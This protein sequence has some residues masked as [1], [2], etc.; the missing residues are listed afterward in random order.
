MN[1]KT[2]P[3]IF[4]AV[5]LCGLLT[6]HA[7]L[8]AQAADVPS[9]AGGENMPWNRGVPGER[10]AAARQLFLEGNRLFKIP[11]FA[12]AVEKYD[13]ALGQWR[14]PAFYFNLALAQLNLG[15]DLEARDSL[16]R[17]LKYGPEPLGADRFTEAQNQHREL[18][19]HLGRIRVS[20]PTEGAEITLDGLLLFTGPG[21]QDVWVKPQAHD[22]AAKRADYATRSSHVAVA[23]GA[24]KALDLPLRKLIEDRPWALWKPW[25][26]VGSGVAIAA[27]GGMLHALSARNFDAYDAGFVKLPCATSGCTQQELDQ[28]TLGARLHRARLEQDLAV[29]GYIAGAVVIAAGVALVYMNRP[30]LTEQSGAE[31]HSTG[32]SMTP[33]ISPGTL[34]VLV[35]VSR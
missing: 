27:A 26:V 12:Q 34:G 32:V 21:S 6:G 33:V 23:P 4:I 9:A 3:W 16:E 35:T 13:E 22:V 28:T 2:K 24:L 31:L 17:A 29:G 20:C 30:H 15:Q 14:H 8:H 1:M 7:S 18:Q 5:M 10:R 25:A 11:L 19:G